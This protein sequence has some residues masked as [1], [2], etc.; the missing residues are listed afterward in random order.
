MS[1][2]SRLVGVGNACRR[3][4]TDQ[5]IAHRVTAFKRGTTFGVNPLVVDQ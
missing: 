3:R 1:G 5:N 2:R 4:L